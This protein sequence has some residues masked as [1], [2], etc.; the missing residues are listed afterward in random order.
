M[1]ISYES[2]ISKWRKTCRFS[3]LAFVPFGLVTESSWRLLTA[4]SM[5]WSKVSI[6]SS[7]CTLSRPRNENLWND[8]LRLMCRTHF[9]FNFASSVYCGFS[10]AFFAHGTDHHILIFIP[11]PFASLKAQNVMKQV[12]LEPYLAN[13]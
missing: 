3:S 9:Y 8:Q 5:L 11:I 6:P 12:C 10:R 7:T 2:Q 4:F 13:L 1:G